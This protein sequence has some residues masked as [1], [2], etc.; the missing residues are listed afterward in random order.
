[1]KVK[2]LVLPM[3]YKQVLEYIEKHPKYKLPTF[4]QAQEI[5]KY[6]L[7]NHL[8]FWTSDTINDR[9]GCYYNNTL[10]PVHKNFKF[11]ITLVLNENAIEDIWN[12]YKAENDISQQNQFE[13]FKAGYNYGH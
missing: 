3:T 13:L 4:T 11:P 7:S 8:R 12:K 1:M 10:H 6:N 9:Q 5:E 2:D